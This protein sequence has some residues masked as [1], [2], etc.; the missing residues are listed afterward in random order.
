MTQSP[1]WKVVLVWSVCLVG[2]LLALPNVLSPHILN[3]LPVFFPKEKVRLGLDLSGGAHLLL[4]VDLKTADQEYL[5]QTIE[6]VRL[7]LRKGKIGYVDLPASA[8]SGETTLTFSIR[9]SAQAGHAKSLLSAIDPDLKVTIEGTTVR[10]SLTDVALSRRHVDVVN[11]SIEVIR[12]RVDETGTREPTIQEQGKDR[13]LL[14][15]PGVQDPTHI[16]ELLGRTAKLAFRLVEDTGGEVSGSENRPGTVMLAHDE[17]SGGH[18]RVR[19]S[20]I[21]GG[22]HLV[23]AQPGFD[24]YNRPEVTFRLNAV[25]A[26]RFGQATQENVRRRF[27]IVLDDR[28]ISSPVINEPIMG[29][30]GRISGSFTAEEAHDLALLLRAGALPAPLVVV[31]ERMVGPD[32][33]ADAIKAG[34]YATLIAVMLVI[35]FMLLA[36]SFFG[37]IADIAVLVNLVLLVAAL[38]FL[39]ATLTLPGIAG[40]ALT[41]GMA[42]DANVLINER[43]KEELR[44]GIR[45][46]AA[47][48]HGYNLAMT[49]II[50]TNLNTLIGMAFLYHFGTGPIRGF[51]VTTAL[52]VV[53]SFFTSTTLAR[54]I[55]FWWLS[56]KRHTTLSI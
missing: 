31:E 26:K 25:G 30:S 50:D 2:A 54:L 11:R 29:G 56:N 47:V 1:Q 12:R 20:A 10:M 33:G 51:A 17:G 16:K 15:V 4:E 13:I 27:A 3:K 14:Q 39:Q 8:S 18:L 45:P 41:V 36:Y 28:I 44:K 23:D 43:I 9:D 6:A 48:G 49:T 34:I 32:L 52:G 40:I 38:S 24:E 22:E 5:N 46:L 55:T 37:L 21:I 53:I 19:R 42:V 35:G 7:T